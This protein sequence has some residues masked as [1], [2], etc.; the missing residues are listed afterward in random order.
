MVK[1]S[2]GAQTLLSE[3]LQVVNVVPFQITLSDLRVLPDTLP[4][5]QSVVLLK[6]IPHKALCINIGNCSFHT[7]SKADKLSPA[8]PVNNLLEEF[9][10]SFRI[11]LYGKSL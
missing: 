5:H 7:K 11:P 2:V 1:L 8:I 10:I 9:I 3:S 6:L 4:I